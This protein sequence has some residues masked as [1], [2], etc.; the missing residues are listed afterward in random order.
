M[1]VA[2]KSLL[3]DLNINK[4][5]TDFRNTVSQ[6][7]SKYKGEAV[8][9]ISPIQTKLKD[10]A[11][12]FKSTES[13][14]RGTITAYKDEAVG[15]LNN[16]V[17]MLT[18]G[19]M[20]FNDAKQ[21]IKIGKNGVVFD[22]RGIVKE[23]GGK[24]GLDLSTNTSLMYQM[25][26]MA[27]AEFNEL[28]GGYFG[29]MV[30]TDG[31]SFRITDNWRDQLGSGMLDLLNRTT[32]LNNMLTDLTFN[33]S[34]Y[35]SLMKMTAQYGMSDAYKSI[36]DQ[37]KTSP[38]DAELALINSIPYMMQNGDLVSMAKVIEL[39]SK[40]G[41]PVI[42]AKFPNLLQTIFNNFALDVG[43]SVGAYPGLKKMF[44]DVCIALRGDNWY[45]RGTSFGEAYDLGLVSSLSDDIKKVLMSDETYPDIVSYLCCAGIFTDIPAI[46]VFKQSFPDAPILITE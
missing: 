14:V 18:G 4:N 13:K 40:K 44:M 24:I 23:L 9:A 21:Y 33:T 22:K 32:G 26:E 10:G 27:N 43:T 20:D 42:N 5:L 17:G 16:V 3:G 36:M 29:N 38:E 39:V 35:N 6:G 2:P 7:L 45:K 12:L 11:A 30:S 15:T 37:Y 34:Y 19:L 31:K 1:A 46:D 41:Y 25:T 28:T 8:K